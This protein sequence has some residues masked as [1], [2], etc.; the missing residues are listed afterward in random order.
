MPRPDCASHVLRAP[1][2]TSHR[3]PRRARLCEAAESPRYVTS[4]A[5]KQSSAGSVTYVSVAFTTGLLRT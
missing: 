3:V 4:I 2:P 1:R 5:A